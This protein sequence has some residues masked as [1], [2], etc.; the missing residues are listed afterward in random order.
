MYT[1]KQIVS[2]DTYSIRHEILRK[3][4]PIETC[5]FEGDDEINTF[6]LGLF[7]E[8]KIIGIVSFMK[9][10]NNLFSE[11][12][13]YQLRGMAILEEYQRKSL[14]E[15][16]VKEGELLLKQKKNNLIWLNS[17]KIAVNFYKRQKYKVIGDA[18]EIKDVGTHYLMYKKLD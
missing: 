16:L 2:K 17:R 7:F 13:Q 1:V 11:R 8:K 12:E 3:G 4:K 18:F 5:Y 15:L 14:G 6:H 10:A 9:N